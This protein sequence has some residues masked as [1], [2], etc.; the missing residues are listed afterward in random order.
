[1][2]K[3]VAV[4][5]ILASLFSPVPQ[6]KAG[7]MG[8]PSD[9]DP[10]LIRGVSSFRFPLSYRLFAANKVDSI[11]AKGQ[12]VAEE[13]ASSKA[14]K[15]D[16]EKYIEYDQWKEA[17]K[18]AKAKLQEGSY[19]LV[20]GAF[21]LG[22]GLAAINK[23]DEEGALLFLLGAVVGIWGAIEVSEAS[24]EIARLKKEGKERG[25]TVPPYVPESP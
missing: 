5:V 2:I 1:M 8:S 4:Y 7:P 20:G 13:G 16:F 15:G 6:A 23:A 18:N 22:M 25:W 21:A 12:S 3:E 19:A 10:H 9:V 14:E 11:L 24:K 17:Y